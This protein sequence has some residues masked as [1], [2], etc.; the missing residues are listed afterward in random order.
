MG[1][2]PFL[3]GV[4]F[5]VVI[6]FFGILI[7]KM[8][9]VGTVPT[10][11]VLYLVV[12]SEEFSKLFSSGVVLGIRKK[13]VA[14]A[15]FL[16]TLG[17]FVVEQFTYFIRFSD[18]FSEN[19]GLF[20]SRCLFVLLVHMSCAFIAYIAYIHLT[21]L[22][23]QTLAIT[24]SILVASVPHFIINWSLVSGYIFVSGFALLLS[25]YFVFNQL[26]LNRKFGL[27]V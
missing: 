11:L 22:Y 17:F 13:H 16:S 9:I 21:K 18:V 5:A 8:G 25:T 14:K 24:L 7:S 3:Y 15:I 26:F 2:R 6:I 4:G 20:I 12:F 1:L 23:N 10:L 19:L 27:R